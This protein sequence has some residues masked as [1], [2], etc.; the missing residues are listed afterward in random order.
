MKKAPDATQLLTSLITINTRRF[1][2]YKNAADQIKDV[3]GKLIFMNY[4][5]QAQ[6]FI[7]NLN[8]WLPVY[9]MRYSDNSSNLIKSWN[10]LRGVLLIGG[11]KYLLGHCE[12]IEQQALK[13]YKDALNEDVLLSGTVADLQKHIEQ[14]EAARLAMKSLKERST[15]PLQAA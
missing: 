8:R 1:E 7:T 15:Q 6:G 9:G 5:V 10:R 2:R 3:N 11:K 14:L 13:V 12:F 4:A